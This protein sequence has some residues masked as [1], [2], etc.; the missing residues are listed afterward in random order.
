MPA[1]RAL[2]SIGCLLFGELGSSFWQLGPLSKPTPLTR[3]LRW[4]RVTLSGPYV[5]TPNRLPLGTW[6]PPEIVG[7]HGTDSR[8]NPSPFGRLPAEAAA[9]TAASSSDAL[10]QSDFC[11]S[12]PH[13]SANIH[14]QKEV[15]IQRWRPS[16]GTG[17]NVYRTKRG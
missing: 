17:Q 2:C 9:A 4:G 12:T 8:G 6:R 14:Q 5:T 16:G 11:V 13:H 1:S 7:D 3:E 10:P 15:R